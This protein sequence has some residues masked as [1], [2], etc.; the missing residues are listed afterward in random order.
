MFKQ[1][2]FHNLYSPED[3][4]TPIPESAPIKDMGKEDMIEFLGDDEDDK[5][6]E[7]K[8]DLTEKK[9]EKKTEETD[10]DDEEELIEPE[11]EEDELSEIEEELEPIKDENLELMVPARRREI[12]KEF[13]DLFKKFPY[14]ER[15]YYREQAFTEI[16]P[17]IEDAKVA[18]EKAR[19]L[20]NFENELSQGNTEKILASVKSENSEGFNKLVDDYLPALSR[21]D[22]TA[23]HHVL[24]TVIQDTIIAMAQEARAQG[25]ENLETAAQILNQFVFASS[26]FEPIK[27]L[28]SGKPA[29]GEVQKDDVSEE[30]KAY[31]KERFDAATEELSTRVENTLKNTIAANIDPKGSMTDYIKNV[32][33]ERVT[34]KLESLMAKDIR[35]KVVLDKL[36]EAA[37]KEKFAKPSL[38]RIKSAYLSRAKTVLPALIKEAR[39]EALKGMGKKVTEQ[40]TE[41]KSKSRST[42]DSD[43]TKP[44]TTTNE[45]G[46]RKSTFDLLNED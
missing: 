18:V 20:D 30:R 34:D 33:T 10:E 43:D 32:A 4:L 46:R 14:L 9:N 29:E 36:W 23:Y 35:F 31:I 16:T 6:E 39:N 11:T 12:L 40:T 2:K 42:D 13:P 28:S 24:G 38:D 7:D 21:V 5:D 19:I 26:K 45:N 37:Y 15:A 27:P 1:F 17:T 44:L 25:N 22:K 41:K 3:T 8:I